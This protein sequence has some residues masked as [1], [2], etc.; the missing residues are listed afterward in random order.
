MEVMLLRYLDLNH[1]PFRFEACSDQCQAAILQHYR[2]VQTELQNTLDK[3]Y[4]D[5]IKEANKQAKNNDVD[6][7][8]NT[9]GAPA[10]SYYHFTQHRAARRRRRLMCAL[11]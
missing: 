2:E 6:I 3:E 1:V 7:S 5:T 11:M 10:G 8:P 9:T 4:A